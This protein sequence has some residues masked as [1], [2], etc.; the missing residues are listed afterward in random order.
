MNGKQTNSTQS[1]N[2]KTS[3]LRGCHPIV[4]ETKRA[5]EK[6]RPDERSLLRSI[7]NGILNVAV[8]RGSLQRAL[9]IMQTVVKM[10]ASRGWKIKPTRREA[11]CAIAI[12]H[13]E[14]GIRLSEKVGR[15]EIPPEQPTTGWYWKQY[16]Y[17]PTAVLTLEITDYV[18]GA[19]RR[20]WSDGKR[21]K[22]EEILPEFI[23]GL[24]AAAEERI[25]WK[26]KLEEQ[27][28][29]WKEAET[30]RQELESRKRVELERRQSL[31]KHVDAYAEAQ[32]LRKLVA[33]FRLFENLPVF[34]TEEA[35]NR[36]AGWAESIADKLDPFQNGYFSEKLAQTDFEPSLNC[37]F[38][39]F[40]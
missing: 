10:T 7:Q 30:Q 15:F 22:L 6:A 38:N 34:W 3:D 37:R 21:R 23:D 32:S 19:R 35:R 31:S 28:R 12:G 26:R 4:S 36:W 2:I 11:G 1:T 5:L 40:I 20:A 16:R 24:A 25:V 14:I 13:D 18:A 9:R 27:E 39:G 33:D 17:E 29:Q 8:T